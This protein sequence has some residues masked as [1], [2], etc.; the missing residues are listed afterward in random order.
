MSRKRLTPEEFMENVKEKGKAPDIVLIGEYT[1]TYEPAKFKCL[2]CGNEF[3][4]RA[5]N[6]YAYRFCKKCNLEERYTRHGHSKTIYDCD[7]Y[8]FSLLKNKEDGYKYCPRSRVILEWVCPDC[9]S[10]I[11]NSPANV[12]RNNILSCPFCSDGISYPNKF[13]A[14]L[15]KDSN[16]EFEPEMIFDWSRFSFGRNYRYDFYIK[17]YN[18]IIEVMGN[19]HFLEKKCFGNLEEIK[20]IDYEKEALAINNGI[21]YY[22]AIDCRESE[23]E[24]IKES[25]LFSELCKFLNKNINWESIDEHSRCSLLKDVCEEYKNDKKILT[26]QLAKMF[27]IHKVT[28]I[29]YLKR[30]EKIGLCDYTVRDSYV[31][32]NSKTKSFVN[33]KKPVLLLNDAGEI[34]K[35]FE[36]ATDASKFVG[37]SISRIS[38]IC[39]EKTLKHGL[40]Y[41]KNFIGKVVV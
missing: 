8:L 24:F 21:Q 4:T 41:E 26:G 20:K 7:K 3:Y 33:L 9:G 18:M 6:L 11:K 31:R 23:L 12:K 1:G 30:G 5:C 22:I 38:V 40:I 17:K 37:L 29:K 36:S 39:S 34:L 35:R 28:V 19:I 13:F 2:R 27:N 32:S 14:N 10:T 15:L 16:I 25:I